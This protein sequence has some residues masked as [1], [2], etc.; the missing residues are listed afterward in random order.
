MQV[1]GAA[2]LLQI[3]GELDDIVCMQFGQQPAAL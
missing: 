2:Q 1:R 3:G